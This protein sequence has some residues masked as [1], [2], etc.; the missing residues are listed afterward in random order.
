MTTE[1]LSFRKMLLALSLVLS[2]PSL[3]AAQ[4]KT[5]PNISDDVA[6]LAIKEFEGLYSDKDR[7]RRLAAV[8]TVGRYRHP[9]IVRCLGKALLADPDGDVAAAAARALA[10][11]PEKEARKLLLGAHASKSVLDRGPVLAAVLAALTEL[12]SPPPFNQLVSGFD[13]HPMEVQREVIRAVA[14]VRTKKAVE[15]L[16]GIHDTPQPDDVDSPTNPPA[17]YWKKRVT[18][19]TYW[20][21]DVLHSLVEL[22][23]EQFEDEKSVRVWLKKGGKVRPRPSKTGE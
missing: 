18:Q 15:F 3:L 1:R 19:W 13:G 16:A 2:L 17:D 8:E 12:G 14:L 21:E 9:K 23:G 11:Q 22:T 7:R 10:T 6:K 4:E 5:P 20:H